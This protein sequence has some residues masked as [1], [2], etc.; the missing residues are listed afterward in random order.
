MERYLLSVICHFS[1]V[2][3][4]LTFLLSPNKRIYLFCSLKKSLYDG[5]GTPVVDT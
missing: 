1:P 2:I 5:V 4:S 3:P